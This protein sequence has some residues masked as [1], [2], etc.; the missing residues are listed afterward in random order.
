MTMTAMADE[1]QSKSCNINMPAC[2]RNLMMGF[3]KILNLGSGFYNNS[4]LFVLTLVHIMLEA[5]KKNI[6][7]IKVTLNLWDRRYMISSSIDDVI[8][9]SCTNCKKEIPKC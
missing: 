6:D 1:Y 7:I 3:W 8:A 2:K 4:Y 9:S 5:Q